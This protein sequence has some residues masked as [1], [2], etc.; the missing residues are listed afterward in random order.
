MNVWIHKVIYSKVLGV[1]L[2]IF[3]ISG[4]CGVLLDLDHPI[5]Y[6]ITGKTS[7]FAHI[8][9]A[10]ISGIVLC[11]V[12]SCVGGLLCRMVLRR[13]HDKSKH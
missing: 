10:I 3:W 2:Y 8:P 4:L 12:I 7:R 1:P 9:A 5:S 13:I 6:W 11:F